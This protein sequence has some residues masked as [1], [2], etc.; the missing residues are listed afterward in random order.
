VLLRALLKCRCLAR[1]ARLKGPIMLL[2][3]ANVL[4]AS[5]EIPTLTALA[6]DKTSKLTD[7]IL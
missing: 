4:L 1:A 3:F 2:K 5:M 7:N 6:P